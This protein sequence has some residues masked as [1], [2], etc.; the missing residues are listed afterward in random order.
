[1]TRAFIHISL[2]KLSKSLG[3]VAE[4][5]ITHAQGETDRAESEIGSGT[6]HMYVPIGQRHVRL[7]AV[8]FSAAVF[9]KACVR[10]VTL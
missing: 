6:D 9:V 3:G 4:E 10:G 8:W 7:D 1:M 2:R 5:A